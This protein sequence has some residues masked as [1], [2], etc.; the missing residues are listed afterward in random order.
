[1]NLGL[2][3]PDSD[4]TGEAVRT[5]AWGATLG[6]FLAVAFG[7]PQLQAQNRLPAG[8]LVRLK[9]HY[10]LTTENV[11]KNDRVEFDVADDLIVDGHLVIRAGAAAWGRV[12][13]VKGA[14]K[15]RD[16]DAQVRFRFETVRSVDNQDIP[17]RVLPTKM[18]KKDAKENSVT[19]NTPIPGLL[20]R[21]VGAPKG[22]EYAAYTDVDMLVRGVEPQP[23]AP[24]A[25]AAPATP[26]A[27]VA[28]AAVAAPPLE[29]EAMV[30]F[31]S[32]PEGAEIVIDGEFRGMTPS[33]LPVRAGRRAVE[34]R[35][36]GRRTWTRTMAVDPGSRP[37]IRVVLEK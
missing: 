17:L 27:A 4:P 30:D 14:G 5:V 21:I 29:E 26:P 22:R 28:A 25:A 36:A 23:K 24:V 11:E 8:T 9:L 35:L 37:S 19:V 33:R 2:S 32:V 18:Q 3:R 7:S 10:D 12:V 31:N 6:I 34:L 15:K 1:M 20:E 16:K 13:E